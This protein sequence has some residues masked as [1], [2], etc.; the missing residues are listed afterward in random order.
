MRGEGEPAPED[1]GRPALL[2]SFAVGSLGGR[3]CSTHRLVTSGVFLPTC[4]H[5]GLS[6]GPVRVPPGVVRPE[7]LPAGWPAGYPEHPVPSRAA[8]PGEGPGPVLAA[9]LRGLG[10]M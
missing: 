2:G 5:P 3:G 9:T 6:A 7:A 4:C 1:V 10:G 8:V